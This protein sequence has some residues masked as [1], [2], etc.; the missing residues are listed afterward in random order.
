MS[1]LNAAMKQCGEFAADGGGAV[2]GRTWVLAAAAVLVAVTA[3]SVVVVASGT[4]EA[5][6]PDPG[7][8]ANTEQVQKGELSSMVSMPGILTYGA[9]PDGSPFSAI[10]RARGIYTKL[11]EVGDRVGCGGVLYRVDDDPV[12][13]L[14]GTVPAYRDLRMGDKGKDVRQLNRTLRKPG[15]RFTSKTK[16]ALKKLQRHTGSPATGVLDLGD[17]VVLPKSTRISEVRPARCVGAAGRT[18]RA[19]HVRHARGA[20][21]PRAVAAG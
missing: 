21:E 2:E 11:P 20:G 5:K 14:C 19:G 1:I 15:N 6:G 7:A 4:K 16:Q 3:T 9:R 13:L 12:L 17:A 10:N 8:R 18:G